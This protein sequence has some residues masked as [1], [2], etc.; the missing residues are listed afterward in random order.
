[1]IVELPLVFPAER[2]GLRKQPL[3]SARNPGDGLGRNQKEQPVE[4]ALKLFGSPLLFGPASNDTDGFIDNAIEVELPD[5]RS[6]QRVSQGDCMHVPL[7]VR[8]CQRDDDR[9]VNDCRCHRKAPLN[10]RGHRCPM[11][12]GQ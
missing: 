6:K 10:R 1:M 7:V 4:Q 11:P 3:A 9:S 8:I 2:Q 12:P 5:S